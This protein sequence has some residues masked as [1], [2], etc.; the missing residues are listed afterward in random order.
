MVSGG[1]FGPHCICGRPISAASS[2]L[3]VLV[4]ALLCVR[5][6]ARACVTVAEVLLVLFL[7]FSGLCFCCSSFTWTII[8]NS[9]LKSP[10]SLS[11]IPGLY[12]YLFMHHYSVSY[13]DW[14]SCVFSAA[15]SSPVPLPL[16]SWKFIRLHHFC[17]CLFLPPLFCLVVLFI[18][19]GSLNPLVFGYLLC[20]WE[21]SPNRETKF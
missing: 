20:S 17:F 6:C 18:A 12:T 1:W 21:L 13:L 10:V 4:I 9:A 16:Y 5:A 3:V 8:F 14:A 2:P 7:L 19:P 15:A 11:L